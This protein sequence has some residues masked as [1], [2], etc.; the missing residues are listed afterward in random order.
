[1]AKLTWIVGG[2][3]LVLLLVLTTVIKSLCDSKQKQ[4]RVDADKQKEE[5]AAASDSKKQ[6]I[7]EN[8]DPAKTGDNLLGSERFAE[9]NEPL[10]G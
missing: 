7:V 8:N 2:C 10:K 1:M 6:A 4:S 3:L 9:E 5:D